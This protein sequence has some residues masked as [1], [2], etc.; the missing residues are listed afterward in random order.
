MTLGLDMADER[1]GS[2]ASESEHRRDKLCAGFVSSRSVEADSLVSYL[3]SFSDLETCLAR[4]ETRRDK[5]YM[6]DQLANENNV[7]C[8]VSARNR[9]TN[10][11]LLILFELYS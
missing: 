8:H 7:Q 2:R 11:L 1:H 6:M 3:A 10:M 9:L 4:G 5:S